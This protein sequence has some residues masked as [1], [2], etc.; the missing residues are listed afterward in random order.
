M[1]I[2]DRLRRD[3]RLIMSKL[4]VLEWALHMGTE[5]RFVLREFSYAVTKQL[6]Q[7]LQRE[8]RLLDEQRARDEAFMLAGNG[9]LSHRALAEE[10]EKMSPHFVA[11]SDQEIEMMRPVVLQWIGNLRRQITHQE[12]RLMPL[13]ASVADTP[14]EDSALTPH[15]AVQEDM[16]VNQVIRLN[17]KTRPLLEAMFINPLAEGYDCL[18]EVAWRH[19][20]ET[21]DLVAR[22]QAVM[23]QGIISPSQIPRTS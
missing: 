6:L 15:G 22:L 8:E 1:M 9:T 7:H 19:G 13:L 2:A 5:T 11:A 21:H 17:P 14:H 16:T 18:D 3:H 4:D 10:L 12:S 20:I 23:E